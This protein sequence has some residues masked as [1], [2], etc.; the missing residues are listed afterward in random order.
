[1]KGK[2]HRKKSTKEG[3]LEGEW[4]KRKY[5]LPVAASYP[6]YSNSSFFPVFVQMLNGLLRETQ[7]FQL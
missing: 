3:N 5:C 7:G 2:G 1:M 4:G 6:L